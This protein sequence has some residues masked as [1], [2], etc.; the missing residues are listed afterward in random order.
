MVTHSSTR[1]LV[2]YLCMAE[3]TGCL[4]CTRHSIGTRYPTYGH[5]VLECGSRG[6]PSQPIPDDDVKEIKALKLTV[7]GVLRQRS[8]SEIAF[9]SSTMSN[10]TASPIKFASAESVQAR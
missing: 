2:Q 9:N 10:T 4:D 1:R 3:R 5:V 7:Q 8:Y 6:R